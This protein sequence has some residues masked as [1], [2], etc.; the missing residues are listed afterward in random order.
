MYIEFWNMIQILTIPLIIGILIGFLFGYTIYIFL[1][2]RSGF[3]YMNSWNIWVKSSP[4]IILL[5]VSIILTYLK[6][7]ELASTT[8][9]IYHEWAYNL[10]ASMIIIAYG[11]IIGFGL[12]GCCMSIIYKLKMGN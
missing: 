3:N 5:I 9:L 6:I 11:M 7:I 4:C 12:G 2:T 10:G 1:F 8:D